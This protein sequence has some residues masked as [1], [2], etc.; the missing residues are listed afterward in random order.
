MSEVTD[1]TKTENGREIYCCRREET[2]N[3][4]RILYQISGKE[5]YLF[6]VNGNRIRGNAVRRKLE[7]ICNVVGIKYR[8]PHKLR[9]TYATELEKN[10][11]P[12]SVIISQMGHSDF[13]TTEKY[14]IFDNTE[15]EKRQ[16]IISN[17]INY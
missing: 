10:G 3:F 5:E 7:R 15:L 1:T 12:K 11:V 13:E 14:Y 8:S 4:I 9:R 17:A 6:S 2:I 16:E